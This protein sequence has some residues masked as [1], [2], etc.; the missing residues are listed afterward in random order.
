M[1]ATAQ[2]L[3]Q[4]GAARSL[5]TAQGEDDLQGEFA[6]GDILRDFLSPMLVGRFN[7]KNKS[8]GYRLPRLFA[9]CALAGHV[10]VVTVR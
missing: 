9:P 8:E 1:R 7:V 2:N 4:P 6:L 10:S 3:Q 5:R